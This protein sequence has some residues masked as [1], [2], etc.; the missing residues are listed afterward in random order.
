VHVSEEGRS[1]SFEGEC[2]AAAHIGR[3]GMGKKEQARLIRGRTSQ[4]ATARVIHG[5]QWMGGGRTIGVWRYKWEA[6]LDAAQLTLR[7]VW[8]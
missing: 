6:S 2:A 8:A 3:T 5:V 7:L 4:P 1:F